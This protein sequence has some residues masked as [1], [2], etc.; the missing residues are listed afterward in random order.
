MYCCLPVQSLGKGDAEGE[1]VGFRLLAI[2]CAYFSRLVVGYHVD[3]HDGMFLGGSQCKERFNHCFSVCLH[4]SHALVV[5]VVFF[6]GGGLMPRSLGFCACKRVFFG[7][8]MEDC[9]LHKKRI[10]AR[11]TPLFGC[12]TPQ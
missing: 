7:V 5:C 6:G 3:F 11:K 4:T 8:W 10:F 9:C 12:P 2:F 1:E